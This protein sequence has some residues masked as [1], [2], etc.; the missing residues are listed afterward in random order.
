MVVFF[1]LYA[2]SANQFD[3]TW[4]QASPYFKFSYLG[5]CSVCWG[6]LPAPAPV[7]A[8]TQ[9]ASSFQENRMLLIPAYSLFMQIQAVHACEERHTNAR[10]RETHILSTPTSE[11]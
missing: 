10:G 3:K 4:F 2:P 6:E 1:P 9:I 8:V 7:G 5:N 11:Y